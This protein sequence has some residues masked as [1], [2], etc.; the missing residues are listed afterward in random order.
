[1]DFITNQRQVILNFSEKYCKNEIEVLNSQCFK[2]VWGKF[3]EHIYKV[4]KQDVLR[5]IEILPN[6]KK[7]YVILFK[8]LLEFELSEIRKLSAHFKQI[9]EHTDILYE[10][11]EDFY[12]Y[13]RRLE[14]YGLVYSKSRPSGVETASFTS[15]TNQFTNVILSTYRTICH[16]VLGEAF[17]IYRSLPA[18]V[19]A[20]LMIS[21]H[22]WMGKDSKYSFLAKASVLERV[23]IRPPFITYSAKNKRTGTYPEVFENPLPKLSSGFKAEEYYCYSAKVGSALAYVYFHRDFLALGIT[24]C[25]LFEFVPLYKCAGQKPDLLYIFG[26]DI[27]GESY[28]Y[29]DKE[30][31]IY[32]GVAPHNSSVDYFGYMKKMLLTLYNVKMIDNGNLPLHG[33]CVS[34]TMKNGSTKNVVIIG[35]SG[36]GKSE[37]LEALSEYA[38]DQISSLLTVFDDMGTFKLIDGEIYAYGTEIGAFVRLDDMSS[39]YA[40]REMD[41]AIFMNPDKVNSRLVIPVATYAQI[42]KGYKVDMVLYANNYEDVDVQLKEFTDEKDALKTFIRGARYAKGT[43]QEVGLVESFF[44][45]PFGPVQREE[46]TRQLLD[47]YFTRLFANHIFVGELYTKLG[48]LGKQQDGPKGAA[49]KLFEILEK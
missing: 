13:W 29:H 20:G 39:G 3:L 31:D 25:N 4:E 19:N 38:G 6:P 48:I 36:A 7:D 28:F 1:M 23:L 21:K 44:A 15:I 37:S 8:L 41:R 5:I 18:G 46:Q 42:M 9:L 27:E 43:T 33:A 34:I 30:E 17:S 24:L 47:L 11:I 32:L 22:N 14:R 10:L 12:D 16:K 49:E 26:A 40:Y 2:D 45:N 35:D